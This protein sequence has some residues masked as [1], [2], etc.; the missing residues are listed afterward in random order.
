MLFEEGDDAIVQQL[1]RGNRRLLR[2][3]LGEADLRIG[4]DKGLLIDSPDPFQV[5]DVE[6]VLGATVARAFA[7]E[8]AV[9][10]FLALDTLERGELGFGEDAAVLGDLGLEP[11][12]AASWSLGHAA[13][14]RSARRPAK[15]GAPV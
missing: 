7:L 1:R 10:F 15:C 11:S 13:S 4:V 5:A 8:L 6:G 9:G 3:Q 14:R 12:A 2:I